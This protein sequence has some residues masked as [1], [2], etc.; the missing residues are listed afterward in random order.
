[1]EVFFNDHNYCPSIIS[2]FLYAFANSQFHCIPP[3]RTYTHTIKA[4]SAPVFNKHYLLCR[5]DIF[6]TRLVAQITVYTGRFIPYKLNQAKKAQHPDQGA[7][8]DINTCTIS[9]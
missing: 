2:L 8:W 6:R 7:N 4:V 1:M 3:R 9:G 5:P